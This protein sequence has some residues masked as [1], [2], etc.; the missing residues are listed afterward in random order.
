MTSPESEPALNAAQDTPANGPIQVSYPALA[1]KASHGL[2]QAWNEALATQGYEFTTDLLAEEITTGTRPYAA[3][4]D[5]S[6]GLRSSADSTY[7]AV[8]AARS[9]VTIATEATVS[10]VLFDTS[11]N[12]VTA[13]GVEVVHNGQTVTVKAER[14]VILAAGAF[15]T[16]KLLELSGVGQEELM[17]FLDIP[18]VLEAPGVGMHLQN[19][20]MSI[21]PVPFRANSVPNE[22]TPGLKALAF[23]R[24]D[25]DDQEDFLD[26]ARSSEHPS[27]KAIL[28]IMDSPTEASASM[29]LA[30]RSA[31]L[32]LAGVI[33]SFPFSRGELHITSPDPEA[34]LAIDAGFFS[35]SLD[36]EILARHVQ[37]LHKLATTG[38]A[39]QF[40]EPSPAPENLDDIVK[41]LRATALTTHHTCGTAAMLPREQGGVVDPELKVYGTTN[42]RIVDASIF[43]LI[44]HANPMATVYA[45]AERA[46]DLIRGA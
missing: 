37:N 29:F 18:L 27:A 11:S 25:G 15:H 36:V 33:T 7:G 24:L 6:S 2:I 40:L 8:A 30:V 10:R 45:V 19:H 32:V 28:S 4:I 1:D 39:E 23:V 35:V 14:E 44:P 42:L 46:A 9:N 34:A 26:D 31:E 41:T 12:E 17:S 16:P 20:I 38:P 13:T 21:L 3:T 43:P 5:P 22:I